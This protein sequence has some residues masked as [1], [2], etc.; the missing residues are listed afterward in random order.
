MSL[1]AAHLDLS[2]LAVVCILGAASPGP[3]LFVILGV[4]G[5]RGTGAGIR[6]SWGHACGVGL[7]ALLSLAS[8]RALMSMTPSLTRVLSIVAS[9]Y[10]YSLAVRS[11]SSALLH[12][13]SPEAEAAPSKTREEASQRSSIAGFSIAISNPKLLL[14]FSAIYP[15]V[16]PARLTPTEMIFA[17]LLP[18]LID[19]LWYHIVTLIS[20]KL[21]IISLLNRARRY[22]HALIGL[23]FIFIATRSLL[24]AYGVE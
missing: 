19:G 18:I 22:T 13:S 12:P 23:L 14:F 11:L 1:E 2:T 7:W 16:L 9:L 17:L 24:I 5:Q 6:A 10:L 4:A 15:Q 20:A 3:S 21:G 8:W